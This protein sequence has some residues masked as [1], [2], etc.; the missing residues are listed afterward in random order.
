MDGDQELSAVRLFECSL[1]QKH[2]NSATRPAATRHPL[3]RLA[4][5]GGEVRVRGGYG[6]RG[7]RSVPKC[8]DIQAGLW[9]ISLTSQ[10]NERS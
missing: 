5:A 4:P 10:A 8:I 3:K 2:Q 6:E 9:Y 7:G 1:V